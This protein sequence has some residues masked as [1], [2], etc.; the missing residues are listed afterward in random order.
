MWSGGQVDETKM[1][2]LEHGGTGL[3]LDCN[4]DGSLKL[5]LRYAEDST[6]WYLEPIDTDGT[7]TLGHDTF[8][9]VSKIGKCVLCVGHN[10]QGAGNELKTVPHGEIGSLFPELS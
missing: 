9:V 5:S 8:Y 10:E 4:P 1:I 7:I 6:H 3:F 2:T